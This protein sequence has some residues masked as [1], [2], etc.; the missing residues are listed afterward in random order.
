MANKHPTNEEL[1]RLDIK[2]PDK[3]VE[4]LLDFYNSNN[5][6]NEKKLIVELTLTKPLRSA[7]SLQLKRSR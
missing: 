3:I 6:K 7:I 2:D 1:L 5:I 4:F